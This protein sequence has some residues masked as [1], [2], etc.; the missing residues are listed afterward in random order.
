[1]Y[2]V[3]YEREVQ[4]K[5]ASLKD[6]LIEK[7]GEQKG[8]QTISDIV[9]SLDNLSIYPYIGKSIRDNYQVDCPENWYIIYI[10]KNYFVFSIT[11]A[12]VIVLK[13]YNEKQDFIHELFGIETR[14]SDSIEYW[15]E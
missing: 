14:S 15:G 12:D 4:F 8:L 3:I 2:N 9:S 6:E 5:I 1:M 7:Q 10:K 13:M 11:K